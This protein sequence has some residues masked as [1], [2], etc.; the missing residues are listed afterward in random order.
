MHRQPSLFPG[1][2]LLVPGLL[3]LAAAASA[4][5]NTESLRPGV[6]DAGWSGSLNLELDLTRGNTERLAVGGR[7]RLQHAV[8]EGETAG[9][10][11]EVAAE[12]EAAEEAEEAIMDSAELPVGTLDPGAPPSG[13]EGGGPGGG[14]GS[15]A[16]PLARRVIF[17]IGDGQLAEENDRKSQNQAFSHLRGVWRVAR[18]VQVE[19]FLQ[20]EFNEFTRLDRRYLAGGGG[21]FALLAG[22]HRSIFLGT[23]LMFESERLDLAPDSPEERRV[24]AVRSTSYLAVKL[25]FPARG[26]L[27]SGTLYVQPRVDQPSDVRFLQEATLQVPLNRHLALGLELT[28]RYDREPPL[29]VDEQDLAL[30]HYLSYSF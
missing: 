22:E 7:F 10:K 14:D 6:E 8:L 23:G 9:T 11:E 28:V 12:A 13:G 20:Y 29:G 5:V 18:R 3:A 25:R 2:L 24:E 26:V 30:T 21:R 27:L 16:A 19:G 17:W 4:Q 1:L 15:Q